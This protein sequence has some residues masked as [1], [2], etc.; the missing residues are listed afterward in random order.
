MPRHASTK[1]PKMTKG[2]EFTS[3]PFVFHV[4]SKCKKFNVNF[5]ISPDK[6]VIRGGEPCD[7]YFEAPD[8]GESGILIICINKEIHEV[9]HTLAHEFSHLMQWYE[10]DPLYLAWDKR[11]SEKHN[12][13][14]EVDAESRALALL[15]EWGLYNDKARERSAK[16][17]SE[18]G[19]HDANL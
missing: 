7:G 11:A 13:D 8:R 16:Y 9:L 4:I 12:Y 15:E 14:L 18:L 2:K 5:C 6:E 10:D 3:L 1:K 19:G 17:L